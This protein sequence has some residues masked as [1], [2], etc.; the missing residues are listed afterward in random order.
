M[1]T[2]TEKAWELVNLERYA[3]VFKSLLALLRSRDYLPPM[4]KRNDPQVIYYC[5]ETTYDDRWLNIEYSDDH[6]RVYVN[7]EVGDTK[8]LLWSEDCFTLDEVMAKLKD[9]TLFSLASEYAGDD[10]ATSQYT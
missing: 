7:A 1:L 10:H 6:W 5:I 8:Q 2:H 4:I 9:V 3:P